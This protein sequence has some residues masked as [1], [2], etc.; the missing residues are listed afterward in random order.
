VSG[1]NGALA[2]NPTFLGIEVFAI[3]V[4]AGFSFFGT[5]IVLKIINFITPLRVTKEEEE[6]GL[7]ESQHGEEAY[8]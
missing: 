3:A 5:Y 1:V 4:V 8:T 6:L 7:D 2:G